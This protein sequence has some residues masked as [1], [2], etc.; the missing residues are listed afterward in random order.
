M[1]KIQGLYSLRAQLYN[2][3][4]TLGDGTDLYEFTD[5]NRNADVGSS[6]VCKLDFF[7]QD[8]LS[9]DSYNGLRKF[10]VKNKL[11]IKRARLITPGSSE[12]Q[13]SPGEHAARLLLQSYAIDGDGNE[14]QGNAL[15]LKL[16]FF[17]VWQDFNVWFENFEIDSSDGTYKFEMPSGYW[18]LNVDD[19][20]IQSAYKGEKLFAFLELEVD[21]AGLLTPSNR[22]I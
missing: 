15:Q 5:N 20:N 19:Y 8:T 22:L 12:L 16:D 9:I 21:T 14:T 1:A 11:L 17:N 7:Q 13:P 2:K 4:A 6:Y 10:L 3:G 18:N